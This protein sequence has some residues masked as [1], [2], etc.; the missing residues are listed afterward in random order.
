MNPIPRIDFDSHSSGQPKAFSGCSM[1]NGEPSGPACRQFDPPCSWDH[2][3]FAQ[4]PRKKT[5]LDVNTA[6]NITGIV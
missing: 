6:Q 3:W 1:V 2:G 4:P 5:C